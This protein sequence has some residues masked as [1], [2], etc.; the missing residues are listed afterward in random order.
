MASIRVQL[1]RL[2]RKWFKKPFL[3]DKQYPAYWMNEV[4][5]NESAF[6]VQIGSNDGKTGDPFFPL[7]EQNPSWK[8]L[9][10]EPVSYSFEQLKSN[11]GNNTSRFIFEQ[12]AINEGKNMP[13]YWVD[14]SAKEKLKDLPY[15]FNQLGSFDKEH[16]LKHFDGALEP[17]IRSTELEGISL[18]TLLNRNDVQHISVLHIDTEGYDWNIL[19]QLD[20]E[21]FQPK[22]IMYEFHHLSEDD[23]EASFKFL[24]K[25]YQL[26]RMDIDVLAVHQSVDAG[27]IQGIKNHAG[28]LIER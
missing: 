13:F 3:K 19:S 17:F 28:T 5:K 24:E 8:A 11:Y 26:F 16:I 1:A 10:V 23:K 14:E 12:V 21:Q 15:W 18:K 20:L 7:L 4:L 27:I 22:F 2:K 6:L 25:D 9:F